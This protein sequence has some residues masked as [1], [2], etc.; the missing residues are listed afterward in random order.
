M[1]KG[2]YAEYTRDFTKVICFD[3]YLFACVCV[4]VFHSSL[5][6][7]GIKGSGE[8]IL[9]Q[10]NSHPFKGGEKEDPFIVEH[11]F[12]SFLPIDL[13]SLNVTRA[14]TRQAV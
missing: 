2:T 13:Q 6:E 1:G 11:P 7:T 5:L 9:F 3:Y 14:M 12:S 8:K 10:L 4:C